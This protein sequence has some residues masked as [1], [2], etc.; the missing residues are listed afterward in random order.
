MSSTSI[1]R[2]NGGPDGRGELGRERLEREGRREMMDLQVWKQHREEMMREVRQNR[3]AKGWR[4]S[5]RHNVAG[6][7][8]TLV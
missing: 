4:G 8:Y 2:R 7:A 6:L 5:R 3:L 1:F